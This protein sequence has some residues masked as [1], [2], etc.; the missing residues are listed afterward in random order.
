MRK[1]N[2]I[3]KEITFNGIGLHSGKKVTMTLKPAFENT[4]IVFLYNDGKVKEFIPYQ[5]TNVVDTRN[6]I[7]I[8]NGRAVIKTVEHIT[9]ALYGMKVDNCI[10]E[11][12]ASEIPIM[13]GSAS[14]FV[15]GLSEAGIVSQNA[16]KPEF[17][18]ASPI[19]VKMEERFVLILPHNCLKINSTISFDNSP[20]GVQ[21]FSIELTT[22]S[23]LREI[24]QA[25]TFGFIEDLDEYYKNGLVLGANLDNVHVFSKKEKKVINGSRYNDEPVRHKILDLVGALALLPFDLKGYVVSYKGGHSIDVVFVKKI[26]EAFTGKFEKNTMDSSYKESYKN[27]IKFLNIEDIQ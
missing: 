21:N 10:I 2:T 19:W 15:K 12:N 27:L 18:V 11:V 7:S 23:Y 13:D 9:S 4:G 8:S 5:Y 1:Q 17:L 26:M 3:L 16:V 25:R 22:E 6:N 24:A 20:I 14:E